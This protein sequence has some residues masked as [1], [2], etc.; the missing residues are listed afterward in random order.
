MVIKISWLKLK[1]LFTVVVMWECLF[2]FVCVCVCLSIVHD[3][4]F[5]ISKVINL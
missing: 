2:A 5:L 1:T 4:Q 3:K